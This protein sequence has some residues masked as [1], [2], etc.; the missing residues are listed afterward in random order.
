LQAKL[1]KAKTMFYMNPNNANWL[2]P[3]DAAKL[4]AVGIKD[5]AV[6][7]GYVGGVSSYCT[8]FLT[9]FEM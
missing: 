3:A 4:E 9:V 6:I 8:L 2:K 1:G 7:D 5:H